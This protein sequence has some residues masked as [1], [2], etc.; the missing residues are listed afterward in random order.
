ALD[1]IAANRQQ[2]KLLGG[3]SLYNADILK[4]GQANAVDIVLS[5]A[6]HRQSN[7]KATFPED[8]QNLWGGPV[9][10][11]TAMAYDATQAIAGG[12]QA[13]GQ[14]PT[15]ITAEQVQ[16]AMA[17]PAFGAEGATEI[18]QF[19]PSGDRSLP[20]QLVTVQADPQAEFGY[21][22]VPIP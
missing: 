4:I 18:V 16:Q 2:L 1:V 21:S 8:A 13:T 14:P 12:I 3:D 20:P 10:W 11:R 7:P 15:S 17:Q 6:W 5:A 22:F 9:S 19:L